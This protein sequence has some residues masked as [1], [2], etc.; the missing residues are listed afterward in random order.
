MRIINNTE[1]KIAINAS[2]GPNEVINKELDVGEAFDYKDNE[3]GAIYLHN[4]REEK[5]NENNKKI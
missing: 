4:I 1:K 2:K 5:T 3:L